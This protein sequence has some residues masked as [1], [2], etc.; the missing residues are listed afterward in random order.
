MI[1]AHVT[2]S[3]DMTEPLRQ[4]EADMPRLLNT[5]LRI[6]GYRYRKHIRQDYLSGQMLSKR[7]G[8]LDASISVGPKRREKFVY[9]I[10]SRRITN[11]KTGD[12][13]FG[14]LK[15]SNIYEKAGGYTILPKNKKALRWVAEDGT[16]VFSKK[17]VG[18]PRPFMT[19]SAKDFPWAQSFNATVESVV[20][21]ELAKRLA[22]RGYTE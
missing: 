22:S 9:I 18:K 17:S 13:T 1:S 6:V 5:V 4:F 8:S 14:S 11:K 21:K 3:D 15:L 10:G 16:V 12:S 19:E 20:A 2:I 7:S